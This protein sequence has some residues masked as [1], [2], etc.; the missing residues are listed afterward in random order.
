MKKYLWV[1][2]I[3]AGSLAL[4]ESVFTVQD[5]ARI[6]R[7]LTVFSIVALIG[8]ISIYISERKVAG[9]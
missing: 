7:L 4:F 6:G 5:F 2:H 9:R 1:L 3:T 8:L